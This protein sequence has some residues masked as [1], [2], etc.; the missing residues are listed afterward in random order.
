MIEEVEVVESIV[1]RLI[2][3]EEGLSDVELSTVSFGTSV[4]LLACTSLSLVGGEVAS[5]SLLK[6]SAM[7]GFFE[8]VVSEVSSS[9]SSSSSSGPKAGSDTDTLPPLF[10]EVVPELPPPPIA[11][12]RRF[13]PTVLIN[14]PMI[15]CIF[16]SII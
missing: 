8:D 12:A 1:S 9:L 2:D 15:C 11:P 10:V 3:E 14:T 4:G 6:R 13:L 16:W 7:S 5:S